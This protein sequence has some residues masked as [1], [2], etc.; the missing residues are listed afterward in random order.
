MS[1]HRT[2]FVVALVLLALCVLVE[3]GASVVLPRPVASRAD[4]EASLRAENAEEDLSV[5]DVLAMQREHPPTPGVGIPSL[6]LVDGLLLFSLGLMGASLLLSERLH[7]QVQGAVSLLVAV[8]ALLAGI[9]LALVLFALL[10]TM[11]SLL[12]S[13]P[14][15]TI[16][17]LALWGFFNRSGAA[18]TLGLLLLLKLAAA[19]CLVIAQPRFLQNKGLVL[20]FLTSLLAQALVGFLH[21]W[22]PS[23]LVSIADAVGGLVVLVLGLLW[24]VVLLLGALVSLFRVL[25]LKRTAS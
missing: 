14:F 20:L 19:L 7:G 5:E 6:A 4:I 1:L 18:A 15:G 22:V 3:G 9:V 23:I 12:L 11:V 10:M 2:W 8:L 16:A 21:G 13:A 17:Y 25:K 24:A